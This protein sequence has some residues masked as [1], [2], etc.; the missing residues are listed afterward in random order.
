MKISLS[1]LFKSYILDLGEAKKSGNY[2]TA[3][4]LLNYIKAYQINASPKDILL[5]GKEIKKEMAYNQSNL[6]VRVKKLV[7]LF[8]SICFVIRFLECISNK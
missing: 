8:V 4:A 1:R 2:A 3:Q 6:F 5:S 7:R